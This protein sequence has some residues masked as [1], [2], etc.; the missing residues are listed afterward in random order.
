MHK[1]SVWIPGDQL[2]ADHPALSA[3]EDK[4]NV[5]VV[6]VESQRRIQKQPYQRKK[7]VLL[8]SAMRHFAEDLRHQGYVVDYVKA[9]TFRTGLKK[10]INQN[11]STGLITMAAATYEGRRFQKGLEKELEVPISILPNTQFLV[12]SYNPIPDPEPEKRYVMESFYRE[13]RRHFGL[14]MDGKEPAGGKWNFD[15]ENR[16][17]LPK[18][19][20]PPLPLPFSPDA[21]TEEVITEVAA[22][23]NGV[24]TVDGFD[25]A[26]TRTQALSALE[27]F[28]D[29]RLR[30]FGDYEDALTS[31]SHIVY[32]SLLSPYLNLGLLEP[33]ELATAVEQAY[34]AGLVPLN[35]AEGFIRQIIGWREFMYWQYWRQ[36]PGLMEKNSWD[37]QRELPS[38]VWTGETD[39]ACLGFAIKRALNTG[40]NHHI[41]RLMLLCN[42]FMLSGINPRKV[43]DWFLS[44][45]VDAFEWVMPP[46]V[47]G[48]GLNAD[49]GLTSIKP[50]IASANY[51]NKMGD[52]CAACRYNPKQRLGEDACPF[53]ALYWNFVLK[54]E[55]RLRSNPRTTRSVWGLRHFDPTEREH[56]R[57]QAAALL[58]SLI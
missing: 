22:M 12:G 31:Q 56:V 11:N 45:F 29:H 15:A 41:E 23:P 3:V 37:A 35:S 50:Y 46:N 10:H 47:I 9:D 27:D 49:G 36:M 24:G 58:D 13:M 33:L 28:L 39:M 48:M 54:H 55:D 19:Q 4:D 7:L 53:N 20:K 52:H 38:F 6:I 8:L 44:L 40:Y 16:K 17:K 43:N 1:P 26:V 25:Y 57:H 42:F 34:D 30:L 14:L 18:N 21:I 51:I 32:H 5:Q 2:L